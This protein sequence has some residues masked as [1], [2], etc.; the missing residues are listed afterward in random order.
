M[1][2]FVVVGGPSC[3]GKGPLFAALKRF[4]PEV[5]GGFKQLVLFNDREP[6]PG[7][8]DGV[9]YHFRPRKEI[10]ALRDLEGYVVAEVRGDLQ[11]L[12]VDQVQQIMDE[13]LDPFFEG[14]PFIP[15]TLR[16][17][18][19]FDRFSALTVFLSPLSRDE[20]LYLTAPER[21]VDLAAFVTD[22][23]RRKLLHRTRRQKGDLS[24]KDL[25]N[26]ERRAASA[27][28]ELREGWRFDHVIPVHD[29]EANDNWDAFYYPI[30]EARRAL[31]AFALLLQGEEPRDVEVWE[32]GLI[33]S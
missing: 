15:A 1:G 28:V 30:G 26:I 6:R 32:D 13:G 5:A 22:V 33:P 23:Q 7:E 17:A 16:K 10:E 20:V 4:Y 2:R 12:E 9:D 14:N 21:H 29:G 25:E 8:E 24:F 19:V 11:A 18:G 3:V 31:Q 27:I